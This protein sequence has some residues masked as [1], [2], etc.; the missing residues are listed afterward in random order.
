MH[1]TNLTLFSID[2]CESRKACAMVSGLSITIRVSIDVREASVRIPTLECFLSPLLWCCVPI[3]LSRHGLLLGQQQAGL[4]SIPEGF[5]II[6]F[7]SIL[8]LEL[9]SKDFQQKE[10][11][12]KDFEQKKR[13]LNEKELILI[14]MIWPNPTFQSVHKQQTCLISSHKQ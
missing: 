6:N 8:E 7:L 13:K 9:E 5:G 3:H 11:E 2:Y 10:L 4:G 12:M 14:F 1:Q